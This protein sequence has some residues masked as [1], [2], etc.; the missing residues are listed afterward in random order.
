MPV[1]PRMNRRGGLSNI[2]KLFPD[3]ELP[4]TPPKDIVRKVRVDALM[5]WAVLQEAR[6]LRISEAQVWRELARALVEKHR[7]NKNPAQ[8]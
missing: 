8:R 2:S 4:K 6:E 1:R 3:V 5:G 7:K